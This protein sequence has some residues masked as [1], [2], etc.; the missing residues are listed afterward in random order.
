LVAGFIA[1]LL[2]LV[3]PGSPADAI[4]IAAAIR[5]ERSVVPQKGRW[6]P[7]EKPMRGFSKA[8]ALA[9]LV[10]LAPSGFA[11]DHRD[12][13]KVK[14][15]PSTDINDVYAWMQGG[16]LALIMTVSPLADTGSKFSNAATYTFHIN[17]S[18]GYGMAQTETT[19]VCDFDTAQK[20]Q[21]WAGD[22]AAE[23][24]T[25][26]ASAA[27]GIATASGKFKVHAGLHDDPFFF[28][29]EG[30]ND[31]RAAVLAAASSLTFDA[32][33]CP[34]LDM[35]TSTALVGLLTHTK[36][37]ASPVANFFAGKN[38]LAIA[39][40]IDLSLLKGSGAILGVWASTNAK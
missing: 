32:A 19:V 5:P 10:G 34:A 11:A 37:G 35:D 38:T 26:D 20:I 2:A 29:L 25:G 16:K 15:D 8:G 28:N 30:F 14:S 6:H 24:V 13:P 18:A 3:Y 31:A 21:C 17:R 36:N 33:G 40:E 22:A 4:R 12:G 39:A 1:D 27:A 23:Y 7:K 9:L